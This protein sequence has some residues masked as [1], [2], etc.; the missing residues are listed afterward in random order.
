[1]SESP[2]VLPD[3]IIPPERKKETRVVTVRMTPELH[4]ALK[5]E[6][7][8]NKTSVNLLAIT[9]LRIAGE[10]LRAAMEDV[11]LDMPKK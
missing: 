1:M 7:W 4:D 6:A 9:K 8:R 2:N 10:A 5:E 3:G 11:G